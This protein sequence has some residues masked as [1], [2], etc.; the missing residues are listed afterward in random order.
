MAES[1]VGWWHEVAAAALVGT[2][3]RPVPELPGWPVGPRDDAE[4][5]IALLDA[6]ALGSAWRGAGVVAARTDVPEPAPAE[7][8]PE[9]P[10]RAVQ[11]LEVVLVQ[12]PGGASLQDVL[13]EAWLRAA[14]DHATRL[15]HDA[16]TRVL[17]LVSGKPRLRRLVVPVMGERGRWLAR[18]DP[19][20]SWLSSDVS[21][22]ATG[23][24]ESDD[25]LLL[26]R[27][28][29]MGTDVRVAELTR[30]RGREG[31]PDLARRLVGSTWGDDPARV[32]AEMLRTFVVGLGADD[33]PVLEAALDDRAGAVRDAATEL[34]DRVPRSARAARMG[35][36]LTPLLSVSGLL[37][38][39]IA[40]VDPGDP[41]A[42]GV[43]DGLRAPPRGVSARGHH[44]RLIVLGAPLDTWTGATG[45]RPDQVFRA[46]PDDETRMLLA[47][48][49]LHQ[50]EGRPEWVRAA[51]ETTP[52]PA[53]VAMLP[54]RERGD[55]V[56]ALLRA[57]GPV[58]LRARVLEHLPGPWDEHLSALVV[59]TLERA[60]GGGAAAAGLRILLAERLS[61][62]VADRLRAWAGRD[63]VLEPTER[64]L[65]A[66][67]AAITT[68]QSIHDAFSG[69]RR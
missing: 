67:A 42:A 2:G 53:L 1:A 28:P 43:R 35:E 52:S 21:T 25:A 26:D 18:L 49:V 37:R 39:S 41:D 48:A 68:R 20:L 3:R 69:D 61:T 45:L 10:V 8:L 22:W 17:A 62:D 4:P 58:G 6:A 7:A 30:L 44:R 32:R 27:W 60:E 57:G 55:A 65:T 63:A 13:V 36:R 23:V 29:Q 31:R 33:E 40:L 66:L 47:T 19:S 64:A 59:S 54:E 50:G 34:L 5:A 14:A 15:P 46:L 56:A 24:D 51:L 12:P 38:K 11:L 9:A 16:L